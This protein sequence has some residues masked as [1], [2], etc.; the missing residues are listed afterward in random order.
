MK[1]RTIAFYLPQYHPIPEN[2]AWWGRGF[3]EWTNVTAARPRFTEHSQPHLPAD[4]GFYDLRLPESRVAQADLARGHGISGFCYYHYWFHGKQLLQR[5]F[6]EVLRSGDPDFPF[7][8]CWANEHWTRSW[9]GRDRDVLLHQT[10]SAEDDIRHIRQLAA[11]FRDP[12]YM[13]I[14]GKPIFLVYRV[15]KL[16]DPAATAARWRQECHALGI[17]EISLLTVESIQEC[18]GDPR[19]IGFDY[20]VEFQPDWTC[21]PAP[22]RRS[23]R[24]RLMRRL[25]LSSPSFVQDSV[26]SYGAVVDGMRTKPIPSYPRFPCVTPSWDNSARRAT[27]ATILHGSTPDLYAEWL[28]HEV[29]RLPER[30]LPEPILFINA[31]NEWAEGNHLEPD[32]HWG[33][34]YLEKTRE[35]LLGRNDL[36]K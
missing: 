15:S 29:S 21:L 35:I 3:T 30:R 33:L 12:R 7:C 4:L 22:L 23:R 11:A 1:I 8:L 27:Y 16:P 28:D 9:N 31:W 10:Y 13:R 18:H 34:Q 36:A 26:F 6:E 2:D 17:G 25:G 14:D 19:E 20:A 24:W 32:Q 5:P